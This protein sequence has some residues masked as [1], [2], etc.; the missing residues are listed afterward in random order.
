MSGADVVITQ[1]SLGRGLQLLETETLLP[2]P[3]AEVFPFFSAAE[4]L[5]AI[6]PPELH[7]SVLTPTP[8]VIDVGTL[9]DYRLRLFGIPFRWRTRIPMWQP[10]RR[11][12]DEQQRGPYRYWH[13][14]HCFEPVHGGTL[15]RDIVHY[16]LPLHPLSLPV[17][18]LVRRQLQ[19]IFAYRARTIG[20][21]FAGSA[22][23][24]GAQSAGDPAAADSDERCRPPEPA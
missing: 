4:N 9:I 14:E 16:R 21:R 19:R 1:R 3:V 12:V 22:Q 18:L 8:I 20:Q 6:T 2:M 5:E 15:M 17:L 10:P 24:P 11:F 23:Q 13:H 7:F